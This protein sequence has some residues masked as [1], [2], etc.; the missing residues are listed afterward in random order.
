MVA[1][2]TLYMTL[3]GASHSAN[4]ELKFNQLRDSRGSVAIALFSAGNSKDFPEKGSLINAKYGIKSGQ[5]FI[6]K[7]LPK[8]TYAI[9]AFHDANDDGVLN[10]SFLGIPR[11]GIAFSNN[12]TLYFGAPSFEKC[13]FR[14]EEDQVIEL[15]FKYY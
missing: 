5:A 3:V 12:P 10:T 7:D 15:D 6:F 9:A 2:L 13:S 4:L 11:E 14:L 8:G 1:A